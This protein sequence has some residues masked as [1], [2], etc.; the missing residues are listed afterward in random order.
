MTT[1][2]LP[3]LLMAWAFAAGAAVGSFLNVVIA[4]LPAGESVVRPRS[5]CPGCRTPIAWYDNLPVLSWILLRGRCRK[6]RI[7]ISFRS[8]LALVSR[9]Q[10]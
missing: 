8:S 5:R 10:S 3:G 6:C 1:S 2:A 7:R 4:R 9:T